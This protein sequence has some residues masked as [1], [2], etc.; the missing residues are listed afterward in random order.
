MNNEEDE[1]TNVHAEL[2][3]NNGFTQREIDVLT[4]ICTGISDKQIAKTLLISNKTVVAHKSSAYQKIGVKN[5][6]LN[7]RCSAII[8][9]VADEIIKITRVRIHEAH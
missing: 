1:K 6:S 7:A 8:N 2:L 3:K 9:L 5:K 4:L